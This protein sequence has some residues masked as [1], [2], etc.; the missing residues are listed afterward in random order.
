VI[1]EYL[2][3]L[4]SCTSPNRVNALHIALENIL[5]PEEVFGLINIMLAAVAATENGGATLADAPPELNVSCVALALQAL[6]ESHRVIVVRWVKALADLM[7][8]SRGETAERYARTRIGEY[9]SFYSDGGTTTQK[10]LLI[11]F[12]GGGQRMMM[13]TAVFLQ[14]LP[15][16]DYDV[17]VLRDEARNGF[18]TGIPGVAD[19]LK[20]L[21]GRIG[22]HQ[23]HYYRQT[24]SLGVS[25]GGIPALWT[26]LQLGLDKGIAVGPNHP[27]DSR[28]LLWDGKGVEVP[29]RQMI[30]QL[31][32]KPKLLVVYGADEVRDVRAV[33]VLRDIIPVEPVAI[34]GQPGHAS[35][36]NAL[37][38]LLQRRRVAFFL[39]EALKPDAKVAALEEI[40]NAPTSV[41]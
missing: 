8:R 37:Y 9:I 22:L 11:C 35:G 36:H 41:E 18:R 28:L 2:D 32:C 39:A 17:V 14:N 16:A 31:E 26:C 38:T 10:S 25:A 27:N 29:F 5:T 34:R 6:P 19:S 1:E 3:R 20:G 15:A 4:A 40:A 13:P 24:V 12:T 30:Q 21:A 23:Q 33:D 7:L